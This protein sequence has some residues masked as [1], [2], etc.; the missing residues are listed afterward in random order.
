[1][2][3]DEALTLPRPADS[4]LRAAAVA[5]AAAFVLMLAVSVLAGWAM[6]I[7]V[8]KRVLP[9]TVSMKPNAALALAAL[10]LALM[11]VALTEVAGAPGRWAARALSALAAL[12][13]VVTLLQY[14]AGFDL[15]T[16]RWLLTSTGDP[17]G[18]AKPGRMAPDAALAIVL[19]AAGVT[20]ATMQSR[21]ARVF[22]LALGTMVAMSGGWWL[23]RY[24]LGRTLPEVPVLTAMA[25]HTAFALTLIGIGLIALQWRALEALRVG[26][27]S[28]LALA[29]PWSLLVMMMLATQ[30]LWW[31]SMERVGGAA[32][33]DFDDEAGEV[34]DRVAEGMRRF[35]L[36]LQASASAAQRMPVVNL[37]QWRRYVAS[38]RVASHY[39]G[40]Q[41]LGYVPLF[42]ADAVAAFERARRAEGLA[43]FTVRPPGRRVRHSAIAYLEPMDWRNRRA[44][45][46]DMLSEP[47]RAEA[48][49]RARDTGE[50]ALSGRVRLLQE[51]EVESQAG[52]L[53][54]AA[55]YREG[56]AIDSVNARRAALSGYVYIPFR[57]G[58]LMQSLLPP[59]LPVSVRIYDAEAGPRDGLLYDSVPADV[60][61]DWP[62]MT[63]ELPLAIGGRNWT[64]EIASL[65]A[66]EA[67]I[68]RRVPVALMVAGAAATL[69]I[70]GI[71]WMLAEQRQAAEREARESESERRR[72]EVSFRTMVE[73]VQDYAIFQLDSDGRIATWNPGAAR[74]KGY[75]AG[76]AI[77]QSIAM[78]YPREDVE[79]GKPAELLARA[80]RGPA[81]DEGWRIRKDGTRFW[82]STVLTP[83]RTAE[84]SI[85]GF[86]KVTRDSTALMEAEQALRNANTELELRVR[87][88]TRDLAVA[89]ERFALA[90]AGSTDGIWDW[91]VASGKVYYSQRFEELL[92][93]AP[94]EFEHSFSAFES[95][96]HPDDH[97]NVMA[98]VQAHLE[99]R[100]PYDI[101]YR[102]RTKSGEYRWFRARGKAIWGEDGRPQRMAGSISDVTERRRAEDRLRENEE[103]LRLTL[104]NALDAF[105]AID[106]LGSVVEWNRQAEST[107]GW[108]R[109]EALG[110]RLSD[111]IVPDAMRQEHERGLVR[112]RDTGEAHVLNRRL[113]LPARDRHGREF[114]VELSIIGVTVRGQ[115]LYSASLRDISDRKA[116]EEALRQSQAQLEAI[117]DNS[118]A[119]IYVKDLDGRYLLV[120]RRYEELFHVARAGV[121]GKTDYDFFPKEMAD[122]FRRNDRDVIAG[123][124]A[125]AAEEA[126]PVD[127]VL[128]T[129]ISVKFPLSDG[130]GRVYATC[131]I[132][133]DITERKAYEER[134]KAFADRLEASNRELEEFA[135]VASHDLQEPLRKVAS[136]A[137]RLEA[138]YSAALDDQARDYIARM[139]D[140]T[141]RMGR[142]I[143]DLLTYS[144]V[145][146]RAQPFQSIDLSA[147]AREVLSD[148][149][150]RIEDTGAIVEIG[151]LPVIEADRTQMQQ[152]LQNLIG[153]ALKFRREDATPVIRVEAS[154]EREAGR[155]LCVL[156][157]MDNGI[158]FD[159]Q[160]AE[161]IFGV[162]Q[163][164]HGRTEYEGSGVG[165]AICRK[166][167][168][169]HGGTI[170]AQSAPGEGAT[171]I[172]KLPVSKSGGS[173]HDG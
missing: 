86:V 19:G 45:G 146:T 30:F 100:E 164:L 150:V 87:E 21:V 158:G 7:E 165:L 61:R 122:D 73:A 24:G 162:F 133:T 27:A 43:D 153:N 110:Q 138:K 34:R 157:V 102:L 148:L 98:A 71:G 140:A 49:D 76:E 136:F 125:I 32:W 141:R 101:E 109:E 112:L 12:L 42:S 67:R 38:L 105:I 6:D 152:L 55:L 119:V 111:M 99:R 90:V 66:L 37:D 51:T 65:P 25:L 118:T 126:A 96:L 33:R 13:G 18:T 123:G 130:Q 3:G 113:E 14:L 103:R 1:M 160:Y 124:R 155:E 154:V 156:K 56:S 135:R 120:N 93:Y 31:S 169:R 142:L 46:F 129:Y 20:L 116:A 143:G 44:L 134:L 92:G 50:S 74:I 149:D 88:R 22:S 167:V 159:P 79:R 36:L 107:F 106:E 89:N 29:I 52:L 97:A 15:A 128:H 121:L 137:E 172:V 17:L 161:R 26:G 54:Y 163:R 35:E 60:A 68:E 41:G 173:G 144:R 16:D 81:A 127:G 70:F 168:T 170:A 48:M 95:S 9:G 72:A 82:G 85:S 2:K 91:D 47:T 8:L 78:F 147:L 171:F 75:S 114:P 104:D 108:S 23:M 151:E 59:D 58:H 132:S 5:L 62:L 77:G 131:G 63:A 94:G 28:A 115:K 145:T 69:L 64:L 83:L 39:P 117:I 53:F 11:L 84:G 80:R 10:G 57:A 40:I 139:T 166:I 4:G